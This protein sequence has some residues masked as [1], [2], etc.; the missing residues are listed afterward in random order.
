MDTKQYLPQFDV[1]IEIIIG[2][3]NNL[4]KDSLCKSI[5]KEMDSMSVIIRVRGRKEK[6]FDW[7]LW[8]FFLVLTFTVMFITTSIE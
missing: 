4:A 8:C 5:I 6:I 7:I 2:A 1:M 3:L